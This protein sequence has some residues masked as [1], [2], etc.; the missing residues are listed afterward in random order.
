MSIFK[1]VPK[2][3]PEPL[4]FVKAV[5][6]RGDFWRLGMPENVKNWNEDRTF[7]SIEASNMH[8]METGL[9]PRVAWSDR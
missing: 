5:T 2:K 3:Q 8:F 6:E 7:D 4:S 1:K 9:F